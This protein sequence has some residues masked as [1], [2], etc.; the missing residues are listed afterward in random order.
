MT[1]N[2]LFV[3]STMLNIVNDFDTLKKIILH[4]CHVTYSN[5]SEATETPK[6]ITEAHLH[7]AIHGP[8]AKFF[9]EILASYSIIAEARLSKNLTTDESLRPARGKAGMSNQLIS[10]NLSMNEIASVCHNLDNTCEK[11]A[12]QWEEQI[13]EWKRAIMKLVSNDQLVFSDMER[14]EFFKLI[15]ISELD[16]RFVELNIQKPSNPPKMMHIA[17]YIEMKIDIAITSALS[18]Q[19]QPH[20]QDD[21]QKILKQTKKH[22]KE[23]TRHEKDI[24]AE[25]K[26]MLLSA[27]G[28]LKSS[29]DQ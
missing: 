9:K 14:E 18:R 16:N 7:D 2:V 1:D 23:I 27:L 22:F 15:P 6:L 11:L 10:T 21:I 4:F 8:L 12:D 17:Y 20:T 29:H 3:D 5:Q 26:D 28:S 24:L 25:E 13:R 19:Q